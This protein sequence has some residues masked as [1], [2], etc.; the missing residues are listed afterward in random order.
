[1]MITVKRI[2]NLSSRLLTIHQW[3]H[4]NLTQ[5]L[6]VH[7]A[8]KRMTYH[9]AIG[10]LLKTGKSHCLSFWLHIYYVHLT[11]SILY[12]C[13]IVILYQPLI[14]N[15]RK[16]IVGWNIFYFYCLFKVKFGTSTYSNLL[17]SM[18]MFTFS[19]LNWKYL[20]VVNFAQKVTTVSLI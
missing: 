20:F 11:S 18:L 14:V 16:W 5:A 17:I 12:S 7:H 19:I 8:P 1:M 2:D 15:L 3:S 4:G 6:T 9:G 10:R 13:H